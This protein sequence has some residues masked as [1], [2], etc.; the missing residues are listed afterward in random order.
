MVSCVSMS[1]FI[2]YTKG[3]NNVPLSTF[4]NQLSILKMKPMV[5]SIQIQPRNICTI[6]KIH[7]IPL[8]SKLIIMHMYTAN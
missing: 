4:C 3:K 1:S 6:F 8:N 2:P 7:F 5:I